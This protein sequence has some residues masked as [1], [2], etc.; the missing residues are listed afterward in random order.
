VYN[1]TINVKT[2]NWEL[3]EPECSCETSNSVLIQSL[4][5]ILKLVLSPDTYVCSR[6]SRHT[7]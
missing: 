3:H 4:T 7:F 5:F 6:Y 1:A 2:K